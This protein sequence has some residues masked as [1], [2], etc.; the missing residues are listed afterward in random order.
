[1]IQ[2]LT[3]IIFLKRWETSGNI[4]KLK[5]MNGQDIKMAESPDCKECGMYYSF[6]FQYQFHKKGCP[7]VKVETK[8]IKKNN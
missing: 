8:N 6:Y 5:S 1:M 4:I 3:R 2:K 7:A